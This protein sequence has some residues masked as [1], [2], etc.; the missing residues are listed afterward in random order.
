MRLLA[1]VFVV[2]AGFF[3]KLAIDPIGR[4][5]VLAVGEISLILGLMIIVQVWTARLIL[6]GDQIEVRSAF[7]T[8]SAPRAEIEGLR[9]IENQYGRWTLANAS[10]VVGLHLWNRSHPQWN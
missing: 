5:F 9:K 8:Q 4:D 6:D 1:G 2:G 10:V 7:R 3:L